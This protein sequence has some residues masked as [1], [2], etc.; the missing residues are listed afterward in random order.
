[1]TNNIDSSAWKAVKEAH[2]KEELAS[3]TTEKERY[4]YTKLLCKNKNC[5]VYSSSGQ[6]CPCMYPEINNKT[7]GEAYRKCAK[8]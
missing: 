6:W 3:I 4:E 7:G 2:I 8:I 1:M 5:A